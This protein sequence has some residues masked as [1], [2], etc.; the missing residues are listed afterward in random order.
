MG[1][2]GR[3]SEPHQ[4]LRGRFLV[5]LA[6]HVD[7]V[8]VDPPYKLFWWDYELQ[9]S[10]GACSLDPPYNHST[11][12]GSFFQPKRFA[13]SAGVSISWPWSVRTR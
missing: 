13:N 11:F 7:V 4:F 6:D 12:A 9:T 2:V 3:G 1:R 8:P 10:G 5:G